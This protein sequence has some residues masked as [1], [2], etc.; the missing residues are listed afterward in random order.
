V[1][2]WAGEEVRERKKRLRRLLTTDKSEVPTGEWGPHTEEMVTT[3][4]TQKMSDNKKLEI[5]NITPANHQQLKLINTSTLPV[6]YSDKFYSDLAAACP[7][8]LMQFA[9]WNGFAV[10]AVCARLES[11]DVVQGK[12]RLYIMTINV[13]AAYRRQG[14]GGYRDLLFKK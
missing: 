8:P 11:H 3:L 10:A 2:S 5:G 12:K 9:F 4:S 7:S 6:R 14:I 1:L 13:L